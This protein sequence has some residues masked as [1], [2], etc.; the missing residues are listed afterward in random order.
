MT[1]PKT[2]PSFEVQIPH[3]PISLPAAPQPPASCAHSVGPEPPP[4]PLAHMAEHGKHVYVHLPAAM[5]GTDGTVVLITDI[6]SIT[7]L[8]GYTKF[9]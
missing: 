8:G 2:Y 9:F 7:V 3:P 1:C 4:G 5:Q 6:L